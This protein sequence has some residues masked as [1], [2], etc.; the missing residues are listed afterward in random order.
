MRVA[1]LHQ[2]CPYRGSRARRRHHDRWRAICGGTRV[3]KISRKYEIKK[4]VIGEDAAFEK[5]G[6]I[7][8][9]VIEWGLGGITIEADQRHVREILKDL[10]LERVNHSATPCTLEKEE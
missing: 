3:K 1:R 8:N 9:R 5:S 6:R 10:E 2:G 4:Q 7:L